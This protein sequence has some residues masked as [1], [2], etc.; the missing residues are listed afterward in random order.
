MSEE[1]ERCAEQKRM[2]EITQSLEKEKKSC[3]LCNGKIEPDDRNKVVS[4]EYTK[5]LLKEDDREEFKVWY[6]TI[7]RF[8]QQLREALLS[9]ESFISRM[10]AIHKELK[11]F[12]MVKDNGEVVSKLQD[13]KNL[14]QMS[15]T[16]M[17]LIIKTLEL[18]ESKV[19]GNG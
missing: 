5:S 12:D 15:K 13:M 4:G 11:H 14:A 9:S 6:E 10:I 2:E 7:A 3:A 16:D 1:C 18:I 19:H 8:S 17:E